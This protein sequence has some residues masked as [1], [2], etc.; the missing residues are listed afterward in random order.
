[1][2]SSER[3]SERG[4]RRSELARERVAKVGGSSV[5][6]RAELVKIRAGCDGNKPE[7]SD[8]RSRTSTLRWLPS[9]RVPSRVDCGLKGS[10]EDSERKESRGGAQIP[11]AMVDCPLILPWATGLRSHRLDRSIERPTASFQTSCAVREALRSTAPPSTP[12]F[13]KRR[14]DE[15]MVSEVAR[16]EP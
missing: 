11:P 7:K 15:R 5:G 1:M 9:A 12:V 2:S 3:R 4:R 8:K 6:F 14:C 10:L 13:R 16:G